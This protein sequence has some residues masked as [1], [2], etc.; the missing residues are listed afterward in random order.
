MHMYFEE[1]PADRVTENARK[2]AP[3]GV[4]SLAVNANEIKEGR[5]FIAVQCDEIEDANFGIL[6]K[7][8]TA[9]LHEGESHPYFICSKE[10]LYHYLDLSAN[11]VKE[12]QHNVRFEL[13]APADSLSEL[14]LV[15]KVHY[16]PLRIAEPKKILSAADANTT[17]IVDDSVCTTFDICNPALEEGKVW[18]GVFGG[19]LCGKYN[20]TAT[21]FGGVKVPRGVVY[22]MGTNQR[23]ANFRIFVLTLRTFR[24]L[25]PVRL[26][27]VL[28]SVRLGLVPNPA[29]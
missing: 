29:G 4:Y 17:S 2:T 10:T 16:P 28:E 23:G 7:F 13:C 22:K 3:D 11:Q 19:G 26:G 20:L 25:Q 15:T 24:Q 14:T 8:E 5:Y 12:A 27:L 6:A 1:I 21:F 9:E 18:A